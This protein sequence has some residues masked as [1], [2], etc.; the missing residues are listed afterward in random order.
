M[1]FSQ[2]TAKKCS[3]MKT[4]V[5]GEGGVGAERAKRAEVVIFVH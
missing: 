3:K 5:R 2:M 4:H 1:V